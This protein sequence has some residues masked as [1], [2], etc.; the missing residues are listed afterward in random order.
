[1]L[2]ADLNDV[3]IFVRVVEA[4][5]FTE[6]GRRLGVPRSSMSRRLS[7]LEK[8]LG[9]RLLHRT[10]RRL[11]LT[12]LGRAYF[13]RCAESLQQI[14]EAEQ[15]VKAAQAV[16]TGRVRMSIPHDLG[17]Q[18]A[19]II[20][21]FST[22]FPDVRVAVELSQR[23]VDLV[24]EGFDCA[25][26]ASAQLPDSTLIARRLVTN[27]SGLY[28]SPAYLE[29]RGTPTGPADLAA[30]RLITFGRDTG[31]VSWALRRE[32]DEETTEVTVRSS[33]RTNEPGFARDAVVAGAGIALLPGFLAAEAPPGGLVQVLEEYVGPGSSMFF[34]HPSARHVSATVRTLRD[35][36][37]GAFAA[38]DTLDHNR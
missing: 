13:E 16:P 10:T 36:L 4:G 25:I 14:G 18:I 34:I 3:L 31:P 9:V 2:E 8:Q 19:P 23:L 38:K 30:H 33:I 7:A 12:E 35:H 20:A 21:D 5:S 15:E 37:V 17:P 27:A 6:A 11:D 32:G 1:M 26:R 24:G 29:A 28:A 22:Q